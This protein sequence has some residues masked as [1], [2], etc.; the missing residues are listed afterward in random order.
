MVSSMSANHHRAGTLPAV[1]AKQCV[2]NVRC[3]PGE[4]RTWCCPTAML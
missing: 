2:P 1:L 3:I 4:S